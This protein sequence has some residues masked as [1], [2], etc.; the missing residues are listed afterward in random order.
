MAAPYFQLS[1]RPNIRLV[2]TVR[3]FTVQFYRR[4]LSDS[5]LSSRLS[6]AT[7][8]LLENAVSYAL[9][10]ETT[11]R[12]EIA[13]D[14][15]VIKTWNRTSLESAAIVRSLIDEMNASDPNEFYQKLMAKTALSPDGSGL[16]LA[17]IRAEAEMQLSYQIESDRV[18]IRASAPVGGAIA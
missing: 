1:F 14:Q 11:V 7:H 4:L 10:D 13:D 3:E 15:L 2:S 17:R 16:G 8:E 18:C 9:D 6:V 5:E 12:I